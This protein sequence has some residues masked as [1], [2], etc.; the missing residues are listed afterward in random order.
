MSRPARTRRR[1]VER[2]VGGDKVV[3][4]LCWLQLGSCSACGRVRYFSRREA[5][6]AARLAAPGLRLRA[7]R[8]EGFWHLSP[9]LPPVDAYVGGGAD[10]TAAGAGPLPVGTDPRI[11]LDQPGRVERRCGRP[12]DAVGRETGGTPH[13]V[14]PVRARQ[15]GGAPP[16]RWRTSVTSVPRAPLLYGGPT[17]AARRRVPPGVRRE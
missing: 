8:C 10:T 11:G 5:R 16:I 13:T 6:Y 1:H 17:A 4:L 9:P 15:A 14:G 3:G 12:V 7:V 2:P